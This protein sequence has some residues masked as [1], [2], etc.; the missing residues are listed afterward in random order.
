MPRLTGEDLR[1]HDGALREALDRFTGR[2]PSSELRQAQHCLHERIVRIEHCS[3]EPE[4]K[5]SIA[6]ANSMPMLRKMSVPTR[7]EY[8]CHLHR[9]LPLNCATAYT[10]KLFLEHEMG[11]QPTDESGPQR[12]AGNMWN[13]QRQKL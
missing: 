12:L 6:W 2:D 8:I 10:V 11:S 1:T 3:H 7:A 9:S 13:Y 5:A 4:R